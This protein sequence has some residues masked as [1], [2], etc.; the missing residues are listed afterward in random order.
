LKT[1]ALPSAPA[2]WMEEPLVLPVGAFEPRQP[3]PARPMDVRVLKTGRER[4][5]I[6]GLR[7]HAAVGVEGDLGLGLAPFERTRDEI[8]LVMAVYREARLLATLRLV[9]TGHGLTGA[10]RLLQK[11]PFDASI[12]GEGSWEVGRVIMAPEDRNPDVLLQCLAAALEELM[13]IADVSHFHGTTTVAL[14]RLWRRVGMHAI[15]TAAGASGARYAL[16]HG[17]VAD[18]ATA[19]H[20]PVKQPTH[21]YGRH[22]RTPGGRYCVAPSKPAGTEV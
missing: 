6:A 10:E 5:A 2:A 17:R 11:A 21:A 15:V 4:E 3:D 14:A 8:G 16:V 22:G 12:L 7:R 1:I 19:L 13:Q 20:L 9:P 18:V